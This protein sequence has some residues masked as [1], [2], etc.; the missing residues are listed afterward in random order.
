[1]R[2]EPGTAGLSRCPPAFEDFAP[3]LVRTDRPPSPRS[4][5]VEVHPAVRFTS[6]SE[7]YDFRPAP[8]SCRPDLAAVPTRAEAPSLGF[9]ALFATSAS[10]IHTRTGI[11]VPM[12]RSVLGVSHA[13]DGFRHHRPCGFVS[14]RYRVQGSSFRGLSPAWSTARFPEPPALV[15]LR[16]A[17]SGFDAGPNTTPSTSGPCSPSGCGGLRRRLGRRDS[18]PLLGL[19]LLRV[20]PPRTVPRTPAFQPVPRTSACDLHRD[21]PTAADPWRLAGARVGWRGTTLPARSR[22]PA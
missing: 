15:P 2:P 13:H 1:M 10:G 19:R 12:L 18:A 9:R 3:T 7:L 4:L 20:F 8:D 5:R 22:F 11:P 17:F 21:E 16:A 6:S 14:P